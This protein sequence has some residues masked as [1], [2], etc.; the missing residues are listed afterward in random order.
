[1]AGT[2]PLQPEHRRLELRCAAEPASVPELRTVTREYAA[3]L[4]L[5]PQLTYEVCLAV[6]EA[7]TNAVL[8]AFVDRAPGTITLIAEPA[9]RQVVFS[10]RDDGR[11]LTPRMDSPG[12]GLGIPMLGRLCAH[13]DV[14]PGP[15]GTGTEVRMVFDAP[16]LRAG[17]EPGLRGR[18]EQV[19]GAL[20]DPITVSDAH[21]RMVY[22]NQPA[23]ELLGAAS[24]QEVVDGASAE[25]A[26][27]FLI[28][29]PDGRPVQLADLP[30]QRVLAGEQPEPL[31]TRSVHLT[32]GRARWL[33][34]TS[35]ALQ[36]DELAA[37][38]LA[39]NVIRDVTA[40]TEA[41]Y[42][43][44][45]LADAGERLASSLDLADTFEQIAAL[46][47]PTLAD[48][49]AVD[50]ADGHGVLQRVALAHRD[51]EKVTLGREIHARFPPDPATDEGVYAVLRTGEPLFIPELPD[52]L[53]ESGVPD[54]EHLRLL[55]EL[56]MRSV[57]LT[58]MVGRGRTLGVLTLVT[59]DSERAFGPDDLEFAMA[60]AR[61]AGL[62]VDTAQ[63]FAQ[64]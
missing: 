58:P 10:V 8:H 39:V 45:F 22:A 41:A 27:R 29:L 34:T 62:A 57:L 26:A 19:L 56:G 63:R 49:C 35:T 17:V 5:E 24:P 36:D 61:R 50:I 48:W 53:L 55:R 42:R 30:D 12:L 28:T 3:L 1:V 15:G 18:L 23:A 51:P 11:G 37:E 21:G 46:A 2:E 33:L 43:Q 38:R 32:S 20:A 31:L 4:S 60:I 14:G 59:A 7:V 9:D 16:H 52:E 13:F 6:T 47:V 25:L 44:R 64:H 40:T 54:R